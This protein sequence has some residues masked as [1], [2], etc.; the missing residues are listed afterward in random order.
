[1]RKILLSVIIA[2]AS[3]GVVDAA[4]TSG[5]YKSKSLLSQDKWV[6]V[7]VEQTGVYEI[8]YETLREMG[9]SNP[10]KV[11]IYGR[12][13][14]VLSESFTTNAGTPLVTDD[15]SPVKIIHEDGKIYFY[16]L[17]PEEITFQSSSDYE[18]GG[19]FKRVGNNIYTRRGYYFLTDSQPVVSM[20]QRNYTPST[21]VK[22][23]VGFVYHELDSLH[24]FSNTGQL[25][26]GENI[27]L[28]G[29]CK[30]A[31][32][33]EMPDAM[34]GAGV[35][36]CVTY[37]EPDQYGDNMTLSYGFEGTDDFFSTP[38]KANT[39]SYLAPHEP[40]LAEIGIPGNKGKVFVQFKGSVEISEYSNLDYWVVSF[41]SGIPTLQGPSGNLA[42]QLVAL[43]SIARNVTGQISLK[44][45]ASLVALEVS[46]PSEPERLIINQQ[47]AEGILGV[48]NTGKV[49]LL[50][51][52]DKD[53]AQL[54]ISGYES[55]Y[56][57]VANQNLH[58]HKDTGAD[59]LIVTTPQFRPYAEQIAQLHRDYDGIEVV[60]ATTEECYNEFS[61]GTPDPMAI[62]SLAKMLHLSTKRPLKNILLF[63]PIYGDFRGMKGERNPFES[64]IAYQAPSVNTT[65][66]AYN[67]NDF[68]GMMSEKF[69]TD[70]YERNE[71]QVGVGILPVKFETDARIL[72]EKIENYLKKDDFA[73]TLNRI[74]GIGGLQ[75]QHA[76]EIQVRDINNHIRTLDN[77]GTIFTPIPIDTYGNSESRKKFLNRLNEGA[78][79]FSYFGHGAEQFLGKD[80]NFFNAGDV[81]TLRNSTLPFALFGGCQITNTDRGFR[82]LGESIVT[83]TPYGCIGSIVSARDTWSGQNYEFFKQFYSSL[84]Q[85]GTGT[86]AVK[87]TVT[88]TIGEVY[89]NVKH[90]STYTNE[91]AYQLLCDPAIKLPVIL[92]TVSAEVNTPEGRDVAFYPGDKFSISG[93]IMYPDGK[94]LDTSFTGKV[95][96]RIA[97]PEKEVAAGKIETKEETSGL[98]FM[99]RDEL[100]ALSVAEVNGGVFEADV[101]V[102]STMTSF[103]GQQALLYISAYDASTKVGA[104][105]SYLVRVH[106]PADD[107]A[108]A[109]DDLSPVIENLAFDNESCT[110]SF[111][112]SDDVALNMSANPLNK[113]LYLYIDGVERSEA[114]FAEPVFE[115]GR[116][117]FSKEVF[118]NGLP[119]GEHSARLK[120]K[121]AA[122]NVAEHEILF[123][124]SPA[125][126]LYTISRDAESDSA[127]TTINIEGTAPALYELVVISA[128]GT[129]IWRTQTSGTSIRWDHCDSAGAKVNP[130]HYKAYIIERG[131]GARKGHS[132]T[133]DIPVV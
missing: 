5:F 48:R 13:G 86:S 32:D 63:G 126:A 29:P 49:P 36:E 59:L 121:D 87:R 122:G 128:S 52:F 33:V 95:V 7:G 111:A 100:V 38:Y 92:R 102:P 40:T 57:P 74:T 125:A 103:S 76:H 85:T 47:G 109:A 127:S 12:G 119:Y 72:V 120:V 89:A 61:E 79:I 16:G 23:G 133:I 42:Q 88:P 20:V 82:G 65:R 129:E 99:F 31:W 83:S 8:T 35:M 17:G 60:V 78:V 45:P 37:F 62:R 117:A 93:K 75:D 14:R 110:I 104:A 41:R 112:V 123:T 2:A 4:I 71:V 21:I 19:Y 9:F 22:E 94:T 106:T 28:P 98:S 68:Y 90:Y 108:E 67:I 84:F 1:M 118:V 81:Y 15:L 66:G 51:V 114:H 26:W 53:I 46:T 39:T 18:L 96:L 97:E 55:V 25:F 34:A 24:N 64:I 132:A 91:L 3:A 6:K 130:G 107:A 43:P 10:E 124:Y 131:K 27:G 70:Y 113:G 105:K 116:Q 77:Q 50:V 73:Y 54:Q 58:G 44:N 30:V 56:T 69:R 115:T 80:K 11:S 101:H